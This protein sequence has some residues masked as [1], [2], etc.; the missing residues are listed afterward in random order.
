[1]L[2]AVPFFL[3]SKKSLTAFRFKHNKRPNVVLS[4]YFDYVAG[5]SAGAIIAISV[6]LGYSVDEIRD[7]YLKNRR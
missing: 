7:F 3:R 1:M 6:S 5:T 2:I 4:E